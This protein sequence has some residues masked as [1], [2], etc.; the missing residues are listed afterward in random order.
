MTAGQDASQQNPAA[1][2]RGLTRQERAGATGAAE[3]RRAPG[4]GRQMLA[5][6]RPGYLLSMAYGYPAGLRQLLQFGLLIAYPVWLG[7]VVFSELVYGAVYA[8]LWVL[9]W[10][11]REWMKRN[12]PEDYAASQRK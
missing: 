9:F 4:A 7:A 8:V 5:M 10:P 12:R 6:M 3:D 2:T 1:P 11:V